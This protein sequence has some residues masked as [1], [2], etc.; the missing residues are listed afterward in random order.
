LESIGDWSGFHA[1]LLETPLTFEDGMVIPPTEPGL[2][3][4]LDEDVAR[5]HPWEG[6]ELHLTP[7]YDPPAATEGFR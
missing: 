4:V 1:E 7:R 3:V 6:G 5:A 2:G